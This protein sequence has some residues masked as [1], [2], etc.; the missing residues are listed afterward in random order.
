MKFRDQ[1]QDPFDAMQRFWGLR[2]SVQEQVNHTAHTQVDIPR[3]QA[4]LTMQIRLASYLGVV[5]FF[6]LAVLAGVAFDANKNLLALLIL[7]MGVLLMLA[8]IAARQPRRLL[9]NRLENEISDPYHDDTLREMFNEWLA[10][11]Q[12]SEPEIRIK[13]EIVPVRAYNGGIEIEEQRQDPDEFEDL[14]E[15]TREA[16]V[17]GLARDTVW[18]IPNKPR[19]TLSTG[20]VVS[21]PKWNEFCAA[22][23]RWGL[24]DQDNKGSYIWVDG[25]SDDPRRAVDYLEQALQEASD[26]ELWQPDEPVP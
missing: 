21:K 16:V 3:R 6:A 2:P 1:G 17:R 5:L 18:C 23:K 24:V 12:P 26:N 15:F 14:V 9:L 4:V 10:Q 7:S 25:I 19:I 8:G 20:T 11:T 22:L 13:R